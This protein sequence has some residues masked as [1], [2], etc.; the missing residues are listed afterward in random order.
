MRILIRVALRRDFDLLLL[1]YKQSSLYLHTKIIRL[2]SFECVTSCGYSSIASAIN[3]FHSAESI[4]GYVEGSAMHD[5]EMQ[6]SSSYPA[7]S[8]GFNMHIFFVM[9]LIACTERSKKESVVFHHC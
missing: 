6:M 8:Y 7:S 4:F 2:G 3:A 1:R 9:L 5:S